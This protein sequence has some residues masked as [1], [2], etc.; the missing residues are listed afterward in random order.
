MY[1]DILQ[2]MMPAFEGVIPAVIA[3]ASAEGIPNL[4]YISQL[5]YV[6]DNHLALS[7]QFFNKTVRNVTENPVLQ[8]IIVCPVSYNVYKILLRFVESQPE[9]ELFEK[10]KLQ[11]EII[12][13]LQGMAE[14]FNLQAAD[15][16]EIMAIDRIYPW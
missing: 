9:G 11:L 1:Q 4:T 12:A 2:E 13:G 3:T 7:R 16:F 6:D 10:M 8:I 14:V 15:V 5:Y